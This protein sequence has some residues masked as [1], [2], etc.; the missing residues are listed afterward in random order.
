MR[1][2]GI[3]LCLTALLAFA[4]AVSPSRRGPARWVERPPQPD[5]EAPGQP[6]SESDTPRKRSGLPASPTPGLEP[7]PTAG[8][9]P[10]GNNGTVKIDGTPWD[11]AP[12][13]EPHPGCILQI[14]FYGYDFGP[15]LRADWE[16]VLHSPTRATIGSGIIGSG[17]VSI[18]EDQAGGGT[19]HDASVTVTYAYSVAETIAT[20]TRSR[21]TT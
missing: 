7:D 5:P 14:D 6:H 8:I 9:R 16:L 20:L 21:A 10:P 2:R 19:D 4:L 18:G 3:T 11:N 15:N 1:G 13:N 17:D 12:N